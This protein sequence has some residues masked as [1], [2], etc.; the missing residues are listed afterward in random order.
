MDRAVQ[1][2]ALV[3][4]SH[5]EYVAE[6][7]PMEGASTLDDHVSFFDSA[8]EALYLFDSGDE[9]TGTSDDNTLSE[10]STVNRN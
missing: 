2:R 7:C 1:P 8:Y 9:E 10:G 3:V 6:D 5:H 4:D